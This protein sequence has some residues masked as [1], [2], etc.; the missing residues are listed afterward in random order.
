M[1]WT[2][3][4]G[5]LTTTDAQAELFHG[6]DY[7]TPYIVTVKVKGEYAGDQ[8]RV[9]VGAN[10]TRTTYLI[11]QLTIGGS[12]LLQ[13]MNQAG[14]VLASVAVPN[15]TANEW[16]SIRVCLGF[17][18]GGRFLAI[19][20]TA[21]GTKRY[22]Y[23]TLVPST[24][25]QPS[26]GV[27]TGHLTRQAFFDNFLWQ[28]EQTAEEPECPPCSVNCIFGSLSCS[29]TSDWQ[30]VSGQWNCGTTYDDHATLKLL[31]TQPEDIHRHRVYG[32]VSATHDNSQALFYVRYK[33]ASTYLAGRI[34]FG[35]CGKV[36]ILQNGIVLDSLNV[37]PLTS[38]TNPFDATDRLYPEHFF[39]VVYDG[40]YL[41]A[42]LGPGGG[43]S[44]TL[45]D[46]YASMYR[47]LRAA[48]TPD[49]DGIYTAIGTGANP[50]SVTMDGIV[51]SVPFSDTH[52]L[53][54]TCYNCTL[55]ASGIPDIPN[56][57]EFHYVGSV[58]PLNDG[59]LE[60]IGVILSTAGS[61][62]AYKGNIGV[63]DAYVDVL[64]RGT[65]DGQKFRVHVN[66]PGTATGP[67]AEV[68][69]D[70][71]GTRMRLSTGASRL[72]TT[73]VK[74][75]ETH[76]LR[77]CLSDTRI[78]AELD[79]EVR[80][81]EPESGQIGYY[82]Y[83]NA[84]LVGT[85]SPATGKYVVFEQLGVDGDLQVITPNYSRGS[86]PKPAGVSVWPVKCGECTAD[87]PCCGT[88]APFEMIVN[89]PDIEY[90]GRLG[91]GITITECREDPGVPTE[92]SRICQEIP[93]AYV[94]PFFLPCIYEYASE[95]RIWQINDEPPGE[96]DDTWYCWQLF[97]RV[98]ICCNNNSDG[99]NATCATIGQCVTTP[100]GHFRIGV[101]IEM[102]THVHSPPPG[103]APCVEHFDLPG[104]SQPALIA[105]HV[106]R[107]YSD[108]IERGADCFQFYDLELH[109]LTWNIEDNP[110]CIGGPHDCNSCGTLPIGVGGIAGWTSAFSVFV[111]SA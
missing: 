100:A 9:L 35:A 38:I 51:V 104:G 19:V 59:Y 43:Q 89:I 23:A 32:L 74:P 80:L 34:T 7:V 94:V 58:R 20:T 3:T 11:A 72:T 44:G 47:H 86:V 31:T 27:G 98:V 18:D 65:V 8:L 103:Y 21:S 12:G 96:G 99:L 16:H 5:V 22:A 41:S 77:I 25:N 57:C 110:D 75:N 109:P 85:V 81:L 49:E 2:V 88:G 84:T 83:T 17:A 70:Q 79:P 93:G 24:Y 56:Q 50:G 37:G 42:H 97:I 62:A 14:T 108:P 55:T 87:C 68:D 92:S 60:P 1:P 76:R 33:D 106:S 78:V 53:C 40:T 102:R 105:R 111:T 46:Q 28:R 29:D 82:I 91:G 67:W 64:F 36:E 52:P 73:A 45:S 107:Y 6:K 15:A 26:V 61:Y 10:A 66:T 71:S 4:G 30:S 69:I 54:D 13:L 90:S 101:T 48:V 95:K 63:S 39:C